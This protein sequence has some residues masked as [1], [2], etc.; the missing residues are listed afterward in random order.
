MVWFKRG[1]CE[2]DSIFSKEYMDVV[3]TMLQ[4]A[5]ASWTRVGDV[6]VVC[7]GR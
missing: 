7:A 2:H 6:L 3:K 4:P 1:R 5:V